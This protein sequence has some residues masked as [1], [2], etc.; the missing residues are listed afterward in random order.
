MCAVVMSHQPS[1]GVLFWGEIL[2]Q[3]MGLPVLKWRRVRRDN[4]PFFKELVTPSLFAQPNPGAFQ[5]LVHFLLSALDPAEAKEKFFG[6][7]PL[8]PGDKKA[9]HQFRL[10]LSHPS[11]NPSVSS[12]L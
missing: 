9:E 11:F 12:I 6:L 5:C 1:D 10:G 3:Q 7:W 2:C 4:Y 8:V